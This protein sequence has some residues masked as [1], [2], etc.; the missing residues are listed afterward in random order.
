MVSEFPSGPGGGATAVAPRGFGGSFHPG[1]P[2]RATVG[3]APPPPRGPP[4]PPRALVPLA[5][6]AGGGA[7]PGVTAVGAAGTAPRWAGAGMDG[8]P[9]AHNYPKRKVSA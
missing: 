3:P 8:V 6:G 5:P 9:G 4:G 1:A 2:L 7:A